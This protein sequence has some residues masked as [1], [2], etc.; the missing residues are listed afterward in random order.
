[1]ATI[2]NRPIASIN[3]QNVLC[4]GLFRALTGNTINDFSGLLSTFFDRGVAFDSK[5]LFYM[6][7]VDVF[8]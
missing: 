6:K 4:I 3:T 5:G 2:F 1:M 7:K 8:I